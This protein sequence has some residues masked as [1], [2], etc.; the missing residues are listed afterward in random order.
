[1]LPFLLL[2]IYTLAQSLPDRQAGKYNLH[3]KGADKDSATIIA[4]SG[5]QT[6]FASRTSC[7]DYINRLTSSL[8]SKGYVTASID[9]LNYDS[10]SARIVLFLGELYLWAQL[11]AKNIEAPI[12]DAIGWREKMFANKPIDFTQ[13]QLWEERILNHLENTDYPFARVYL[14]SL[15]LENDKVSSQSFSVL[16]PSLHWPLPSA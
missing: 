14:D 5:L 8:Q 7:T 1:M 11:D 16:R 3:V 6:I 15:Q 4:K 10:I 9:S 13:V 12:L 2:S